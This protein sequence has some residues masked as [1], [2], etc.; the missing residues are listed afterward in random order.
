MGTRSVSSLVQMQVPADNKQ[1]QRD[2][3][4]VRAV[5]VDRS[6]GAFEGPRCILIG[7]KVL[8]D[9]RDMQDP[10]INQEIHIRRRFLPV[11]LLLFSVRVNA[12][13]CSECVLVSPSCDSDSFSLP[14]LHSLAHSVMVP[15]TSHLI[16]EFIKGHFMTPYICPVFLFTIY[17]KHFKLRFQSTFVLE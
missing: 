15:H 9:L 2:T 8:I 17:V 3:E 7:G 6:R 5:Q 12:W 4:R 1:Q 11:A 13:A 16:E 14:L 10:F